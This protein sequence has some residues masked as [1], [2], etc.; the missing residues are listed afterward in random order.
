MQLD[1]EHSLS[2][3]LCV[4][5]SGL[6]MSVLF[7]LLLL[8]IVIVYYNVLVMLVFYN[9]DFYITRSRRNGL[10]WPTIEQIKVPELNAYPL[11]GPS[12]ELVCAVEPLGVGS[13]VGGRQESPLPPL[14]LV[15]GEGACRLLHDRAH[16]ILRCKL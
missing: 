11:P 15:H 14:G 6:L 9:V 4:L 7:D 8:C 12:E 2:G 16:E 3:K 5:V 10:L 1:T 13:R